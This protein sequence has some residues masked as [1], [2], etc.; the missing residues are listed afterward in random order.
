MTRRTAADT[1]AILGVGKSHTIASHRGPAGLRQ[2]Q[3]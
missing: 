1:F 2:I 3:L